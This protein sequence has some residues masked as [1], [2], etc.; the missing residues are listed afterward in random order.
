MKIKELRRAVRKLLK[1]PIDRGEL[2]AKTVSAQDTLEF[3]AMLLGIKPVFLL[4]RGFDDQA[5]I[6]AVR[7]CASELRVGLVK[8]ARTGAPM[9]PPSHSGLVPRLAYAF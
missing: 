9:T 6:S 8:E 2:Y 1:A 5:W 4:G 3:A 7:Q